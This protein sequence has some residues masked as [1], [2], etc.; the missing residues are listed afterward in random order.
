MN[1]C[2][3]QNVQYERRSIV[4][5]KGNETN[6]ETRWYGKG[7]CKARHKTLNYKHI[8]ALKRRRNTVIC[9][10]IEK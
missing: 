3:L 5:K 7:G 4:C 10:N 8:A 9:T 2:S 1:G 6:V